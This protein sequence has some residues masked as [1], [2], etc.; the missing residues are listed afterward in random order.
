M[1]GGTAAWPDRLDGFAHAGN[2]VRRKVV[3]DHGVP[4]RELRHD[5]LLDVGEEGIAI[6]RILERD[7]ARI[8]ELPQRTGSDRNAACEELSAQLGKRDVR[9]GCDLR[10]DE[11]FLCIAPGGAPVPALGLR[12]QAARLA[13]AIASGSRSTH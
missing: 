11:V 13:P 12:R 10:K 6:Y 7:A 1:A 8:E 9:P 4:D 3:H 2:L 5:D